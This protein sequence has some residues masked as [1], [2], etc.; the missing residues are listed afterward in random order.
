MGSIGAVVIARN[1]GER[2]RRCLASIPDGVEQVVYVDSGSTDGSLEWAR[3]QEL[4]LVELD[5]SQPFTA[6]RARNAGFARLKELAAD[7]EFVQFIDG[8]CELLEGWIEAGLARLRQEASAVVVCGRLR[9]RDPDRSIY[10]QLFNLELDVQEGPTTHCGGIAMMRASAFQGVGGFRD[11]LVAGE[12]PELCVRLRKAGGEIWRLA[13]DMAHH[14]ADI[15][16]FGQWWKRMVR[17]GHAYTEGY[18]LHRDPREA[19][20]VASFLFWGALL[21]LAALAGAWWTGG[22]SLALF[23]LY[24]IQG[25][26][27]WRRERSRG[28]PGRLALAQA[29]FLLLAKFAQVVGC[30]RYLLTRLFRRESK[31]IE[32]KSGAQDGSGAP[33]P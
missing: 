6:A 3:E 16:R 33:V 31:L 5:T 27:I 12:E 28:R 20:G 9:E 1:E 17:G 7:L 21:P 13:T 23:V 14:D 22:W 18:V 32:Y 29:V 8:D 30:A 4:E 10:Q 24:P 19:R 15:S 11:D 2:L 25:V 26:R